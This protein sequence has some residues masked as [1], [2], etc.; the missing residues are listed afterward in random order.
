M[1]YDRKSKVR[2]NATIFELCNQKDRV[3]NVG[4]GSLSIRSSISDNVELKV[5]HHLT[6]S[7]MTQG[8]CS[9][10]KSHELT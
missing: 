4:E 3:E 5:I 1:E 7:S 2:D 8:D 9:N 6:F 10:S